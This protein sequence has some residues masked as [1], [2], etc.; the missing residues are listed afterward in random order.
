MPVQ[1]RA[2]EQLHRTLTADYDKTSPADRL[3][4]A[5]KLIQQAAALN[6]AS[7]RFVTLSDAWELAAGA[8][9]ATTACHAIDELAR[10]YSVD[11]LDLQ[12]QALA[13]ALAV[14]SGRSECEA[15]MRL[16]LETADAAAAA[17]A[18]DTVLP[19][20]K[21]AEAAANKSRDITVVSA[22]QVRIATLR[23]LATEFGRV[24]K[25]LDLIANST[26]SPDLAKAHLLAG[27]FYAL[28][29]GRW[30][31]G[32]PHL[33]AGSDATL[34]ALAQAELSRPGP[35]GLV[36]LADG[37]LDFADAS[38]GLARTSVQ[39]H[40]REL[41]AAA[42]ATHDGAL[43]KV[44]ERLANTTQPSTSTMP[45][46][47]MNAGAATTAPAADGIVHLL[48]MID[49]SQDA[50]QGSWSLQNGELLCGSSSYACLQL[51]YAPPEEYDL[52]AEFTRTEGQ[53]PVALLLVSHKRTF[54]FA[55]DIKGKSRFERV[56]GKIAKDNPT[57]KDAAISNGRRYTLTVQVRKDGVKAILNDNPIVEWKTDYKDLS[58]YTVWKLGDNTLCGVGANNAK[59]MFHAIDIIEVTGKGRPT[60]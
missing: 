59:V 60:R 44:Q 49:P 38:A 53:G 41:L 32:I 50:A 18:Y 20:V 25:A 19:L 10:R 48:K 47:A 14:T 6:D 1:N 24:K 28:Y 43:A 55:L 4:L 30:A 15:L 33:A 12:Q 46:N 39:A 36:K 29:T 52:R 3:Q 26:D 16:A 58:R 17:D 27:R 5:K 21:V 11:I 23:E 7:L 56:D 51:P 9:D 2:R 22:I 35:E 31:M 45:S 40:A 8:G 13:R 57:V 42:D 54:G 34:R 37:W